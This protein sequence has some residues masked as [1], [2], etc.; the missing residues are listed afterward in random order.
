MNHFVNVSN[1]KTDKTVMY[2]FDYFGGNPPLFKATMKKFH[3]SDNSL[4]VT[5]LNSQQ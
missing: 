3:I 2:I 1:T 4:F 5:A